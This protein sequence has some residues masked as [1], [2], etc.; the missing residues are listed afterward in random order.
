MGSGADS[1][2]PCGTV[3]SLLPF[4]CILLMSPCPSPPHPLTPLT[5]L[6]RTMAKKG[7]LQ[8]LHLFAWPMAGMTPALACGPE[9]PGPAGSR[10]WCGQPPGRGCRWLV[11][12]S[13]AYTELGLCGPQG[14]GAHIRSLFAEVKEVFVSIWRRDRGRNNFSHSWPVPPFE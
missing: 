14:A 9:D 12:Q 3:G 2:S 11:P 10:S 8:Y 4:M 7:E 5:P 6:H 1:P 13:P